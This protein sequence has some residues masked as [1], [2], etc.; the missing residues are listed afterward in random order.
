MKTVAESEVEDHFT[1]LLNE[2]ERGAAIAITRQGAPVATLAPIA[3]D[4]ET[5]QPLRKHTSAEVR[6]AMLRIREQAKAA[7]MKFD[8]DEVKKWR[9]EG[10]T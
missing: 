3:E 9:D 8:W 5:R 6:S 7:G 10:R 2:V 4:Y 1:V